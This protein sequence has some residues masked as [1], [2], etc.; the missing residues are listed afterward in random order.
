MTTERQAGSRKFDEAREVCEELSD[1][2]E[3]A[4]VCLPS[5]SPDVLSCTGPGP[6][7][8]VE[9]GRCNLPTARALAAV[10]RRGALN[11]TSEVAG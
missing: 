11:R 6:G 1:A 10:L 9:L 3:G 7:A 2:L 5:L 4:G 8:L